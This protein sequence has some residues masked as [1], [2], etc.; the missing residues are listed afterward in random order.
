MTYDLSTERPALRKPPMDF[1]GGWQLPTSGAALP[2][3]AADFENAARDLGVETA[4]VHAVAQVESGGRTGFD[5]VNRPLIRYENHYFRKLTGGRYDESHPDLSAGYASDQYWATHQAGNDEQFELLRRAFELDPEAAVKSCS[6][7][8]FQVMGENA[9]IAGWTDLA[10]FV[11]DM[12]YSANQHLRAFLGFC[13]YNGLVG[14]L[15][16]HDWASFAMR[17][18]GENY[19]DNAYDTLLAQA[20]EQWSR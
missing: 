9:T 17:Y 15:A 13:R 14:A 18:N 16:D 2:L 12:F 7:G 1:R 3:V 11:D 4:A 19:R 8:M 5:G 10:V 20:Y 6:W